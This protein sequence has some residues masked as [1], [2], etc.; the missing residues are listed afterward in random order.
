MTAETDI[1]DA[2]AQQ[3]FS[4]PPLTLRVLE[5]D[6]ILERGNRKGLIDAV[7]EAQWDSRSWTFAAEA[8]RLSTP[9]I[10]QDALAYIR[11]AAAQSG[12]NPMIVVPYLSRSNIEMLEEAKVSGIDMCG[13]GFV[14]VPGELLISR[15]GNPNRFPQSAPIRNVYRGDS[16]MVARAFLARP[17]FRSVGDIEVAVRELGGDVTLS[18]VSKVLK[19]LEG[20][21]IVSREKG[22]IRLIQP[23]KLLEAL[24][25]SYREPTIKDRYVGKVALGEA[26]LQQALAQAARQIGSKFVLTGAASATKYAVMGREPVVAAYCSVAPADL[27]A[28]LP[29]RAE[30]TDRFPNLTLART[31]DAPIYFDAIDEAGV[32]FASPVQTYL[33]L[34]SGDKRQRETAEQVRDSLLRRTDK[35]RIA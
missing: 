29:V 3:R 24:S 34:S 8:K 32:P 23:E 18:T 2:L 4:L 22:S 7:I 35:A 31:S 1:L 14:V 11:P 6:R 16:S 15:A 25:S 19:V 30:Q 33:E 26:E 5:R 9:K 28:A 13:N 27:I 21:L 12:M 20:D 17:D 10:L